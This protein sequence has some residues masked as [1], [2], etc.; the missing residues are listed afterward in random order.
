MLE[1]SVP[2]RTILFPRC[3]HPPPF[4]LTRHPTFYIIAAMTQAQKPNHCRNPFPPITTWLFLGLA[5]LL[6]AATQAEIITLN[7]ETHLL[8]AVGDTF[9]EPGFT[10]T[11]DDGN[12]IGG[13]Q[14]EVTG[15]VNT[16]QP[17]INTLTYSYTNPEN[18]T[19]QAHRYIHVHDDVTLPWIIP[20]GDLEIH[21][22][23]G[24]PFTDPASQVLDASG[25]IIEAN[26]MGSGTVDINKL[27]EYLLTYNYT[28]PDGKSAIPF[29]LKVNIF[30]DPDAPVITL[31]GEEEILHQL[32][33]PFTDPGFSVEDAAGNAMDPSGVVV[34]GSVDTNTPGSY[35]LA[36]SATDAAGNTGTAQRV[37]TVVANTA[38][39]IRFPTASLHSQPGY[40]ANPSGHEH[41]NI[42][43]FAALKEDGSVVT[44]GL[45]ANG[46]DSSSVSSNLVSGVKTVF[47]TGYA[48][49][50][51]KED[52]SVVN[53][54]DKDYGGNSSSVSSNLASGVKT[55]FSTNTAFA[56][57]KE[58][59]SVVTWGS[60]T[61]GGDSSSVLQAKTSNTMLSLRTCPAS[62]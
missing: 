15:T 13:V 9:T 25:N 2:L 34:T 1:R 29:I 23:A 42:Q 30:P 46:G 27:G 50:A 7:G 59:G 28:S 8:L 10:L 35:T 49:A 31:V 38:P 18:K 55:V 6:P 44:W 32:G 51:L 45:A 57:L 56:A 48:F 14:L 33:T 53:W 37:V 62:R 54:G 43:V 61:S 12:P 41:Y 52:G 4:V 58:D 19:F 47:S 16:S 17:G 22:F 36:Y 39:V 60:A 11:D 5:I 24:V 21:H 40:P 26:L 3:W 20:N